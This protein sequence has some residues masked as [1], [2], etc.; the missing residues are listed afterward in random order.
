ME[1]VH[2]FPPTF[3]PNP[4]RFCSPKDRMLGLMTA[5][6][7]LL[8]PAQLMRAQDAFANEMVKAFLEEDVKAAG[9]AKESEWKGT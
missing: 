5:E 2:T 4:A 7:R 9:E 6:G 1:K 3:L 8:G